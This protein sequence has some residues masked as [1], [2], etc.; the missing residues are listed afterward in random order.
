M[1]LVLGGGSGVSCHRNGRAPAA[2][3]IVGGSVGLKHAGDWYIRKWLTSTHPQPCAVPAIRERSINRWHVYT[4]QTASTRTRAG[5]LV[6]E[7]RDRLGRQRA[8]PKFIILNA[9][10][11]V[12]NTQFLVFNKSKR[13]V[14]RESVILNTQFLV[15]KYKKFISFTSGAFKKSRKSW[16]I[17]ARQ[18]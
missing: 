12:F 11:L 13:A 17:P 2:V 6:P 16:S 10:F 14:E 4:K 5:V 8:L 9:K 7:V 3:R 15:F 18:I 1:I